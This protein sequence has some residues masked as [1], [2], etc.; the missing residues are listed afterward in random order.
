MKIV[1]VNGS[2]KG[3]A[4]VSRKI[5][6]RLIP[7]C[8]GQQY[9]ILHISEQMDRNMAL[10]IMNMADGIVI[11]SPVY[12][13]VIP[14]VLLGFLSDLE[15]HMIERRA[16]VSVIVHGDLFDSDDCLNALGVMESWASHTGLMFCNGLGIG[17]SDQFYVSDAGF[18]NRH[19]K[20][21][22]R[23]VMTSLIQGSIFPSLCVSMGNRMLY[24]RN[25]ENM[26]HAK[27]EENGVKPDTWNARI[28]R[29]FRSS[30][31]QKQKIDENISE[32]KIEKEENV[33]E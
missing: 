1:F 2:P 33:S 32:S 12:A 28:A 15:M 23:N 24:R 30:N 10:Q 4:G 26:H 3:D 7:F 13:G 22:M 20:E 18:E 9:G 11:V 17:G 14:S 27:M 29:L 6:D 25:M 19:L 8:K 21:G 16:R 5:I 31:A